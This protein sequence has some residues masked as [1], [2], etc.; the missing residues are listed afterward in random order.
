MVCSSFCGNSQSPLQ[1]ELEEH[2][3]IDDAEFNLMF[4]LRAISSMIV[5]LVLPEVLDKLGIRSVTILFALSCVAG[6]WV[7]ILGLKHHVYMQC[8]MSRLIFGISDC[9]TIVQQ[10]ILC[11]WFN[12]D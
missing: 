11:Q 10:L 2:L 5:P 4:S 1:K 9:M 7:F 8:L 12:A 3:D 6:Q